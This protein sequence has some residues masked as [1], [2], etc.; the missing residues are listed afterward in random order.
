M[1]NSFAII[2]FAALIHTSFQL[3]VS[4]LT[5]MSGHAIGNKSSHAKLLRLTNM[6][7]FGVAL[8]TVLLLSVIAFVLQ[9][10]ITAA[11]PPVVWASV[12][13]LLIGLGVAVWAFYY[14][15][16]PGTSLWLP[17][18]MARYLSDRTKSTKQSAEAFSLGMSSVIAEF[19]FIF[20]PMTVSALALLQLDPGMQIVGVALYAF[21]SLLSLLVVNGLIGS[22]HKL[23]RI[24]KWREDNKRFLQFAAG[25]GLLILGFYL[26]VD[27]IIAVSSLS[28][29]VL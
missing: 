22:G 28:N 2:A 11:I 18:S 27:K 9:Q 24:Q 10:Y 1:L 4:M 19:I 29:G 17:R 25:S 5:L 26:Y 8:M 14:R 15:R 13:G 16:T 23:S 6:F 7:S 3:S 21:I 12:C 20:A